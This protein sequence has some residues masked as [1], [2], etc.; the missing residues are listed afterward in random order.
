MKDALINVLV[1]AL[2]IA[3]P[4]AGLVAGVLVAYWPLRSVSRWW[5]LTYAALVTAL[6]A[7]MTVT[8]W[9]PSP[10]DTLYNGI[11]LAAVA[12]AGGAL[13][14][15]FLLWRLPPQGRAS[16]LVRAVATVAYFFS[17][18]AWVFVVLGGG[19]EG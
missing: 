9:S 11:H 5:S 6:S 19:V 13:V 15:S 4:V 17:A 10:E 8:N 16:G 12:L 2:W 7:W 1:T 14:T 18:V 3:V